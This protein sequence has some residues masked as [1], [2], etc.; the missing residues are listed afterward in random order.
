MKIKDRIERAQTLVMEHKLIIE[1]MENRL[2]I[3]QEHRDAD[4]PLT[5]SVIAQIEFF[6]LNL[7]VVVHMNEAGIEDMIQQEKYEEMQRERG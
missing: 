2:T 7:K 3:L 6:M 5:L 1:R 4:E